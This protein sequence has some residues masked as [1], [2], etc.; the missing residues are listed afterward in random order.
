VLNFER[1]RRSGYCLHKPILKNRTRHV[2]G[3]SRSRQGIDKRI[4]VYGVRPGIRLNFH[5]SPIPLKEIGDLPM[6]AKLS[7]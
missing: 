6:S 2:S 7:T 5:V 3:V 1:T 4:R